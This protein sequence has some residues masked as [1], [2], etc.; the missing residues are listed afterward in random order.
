MI[1][2]LKLIKIQHLVD[3]NADLQ[4]FDKKTSAT[5]GNKFSGGAA[6]SEIMQ[7]QLPSHLVTRQLAEELHKPIIKTFEKRKVHSSF[8]DNI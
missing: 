6:K 3:I 7:N 4:F 1:K 2:H 5:R 8:S